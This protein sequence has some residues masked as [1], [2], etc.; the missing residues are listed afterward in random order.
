MAPFV[1]NRVGSS[2]DV[3]GVAQN[4]RFQTLG[5][6]D[7][8]ILVSDDNVRVSDALLGQIVI[9]FDVSPDFSQ[10]TDACKVSMFQTTVDLDIFLSFC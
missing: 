6:C 8:A 2:V 1:R 5:Y 3:Y 10:F 7:A 4:A 9:A